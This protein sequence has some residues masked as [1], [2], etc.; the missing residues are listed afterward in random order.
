MGGFTSLP[1]VWA[2][3]K[4]GA[5]TFVHDSNSIPGKANR[6]TARFADCVFLGMEECASYFP[7]R[8]TEVTGTPIRSS[9]LNPVAREEAEAFFGFEPSPDAKTLFVTGGSQ[10][11]RGIN[12]G[13]SGAAAELKKRVGNGL[14]IVHLAGR[15][16]AESVAGAYAAAGVE[17]SVEPFCKRMECAYA[18]ADLIV[19]R[20][21]AS[22]L[23]EIAMFGLPSVLVPYPYAAE[24][25]QTRNAEAFTRRDAAIMLREADITPAG[26]GKL[27]GDLLADDAARARIGAAAKC[28]ATPLAAENIATLI[29]EKCHR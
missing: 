2:G 23:T 25:H 15:E 10:G 22:S 11:A 13:V 12:R 4:I 26:F 20:S 3:K 29:E 7:G 18:I 9:L 28:L 1:P 16:D 17:Y 24:D 14:R 6:L 5:R 8:R 21:G 19:S 27:L